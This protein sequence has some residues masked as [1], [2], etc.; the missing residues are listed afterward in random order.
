LAIEE[1]L[2]LSL[3]ILVANIGGAPVPYY[4]RGP[5]ALFRELM[6]E[7]ARF[8][9]AEVAKHEE[10]GGCVQEQANLTFALREEFVGHGF[11]AILAPSLRRST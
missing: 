7:S 1:N 2:S 8:M 5:F 9:L 6:V 4:A 3:A 11:F 10:S